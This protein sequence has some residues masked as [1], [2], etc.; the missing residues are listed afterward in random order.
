MTTNLKKVG[1]AYSLFDRAM[2][3]DLRAKADVAES[4]TT[5]DFPILLGQGYQRKL[6]AAYQAQTPVWQ[7]YATRTTVPNFKP[8][9]LVQILGGARGLSRVAEATEYPSRDLS[10]ALFEFSVGKYGDR[11]GLSWEMVVN[12][13]LGA[14]RGIDQSLA[15]AAR[16]TEGTV[17]ASAFFNAAKTGLNTQ[18]FRA[19]NGNA[20]ESAPLTRAALQDAIQE[21]STKKDEQGNPLTRPG[22]VL[23]VPPTL[24][25]QAREIL[26]ASEIRTTDANGAVSV[27]QNPVAGA[28]TLVVEPNLL[29]NTGSNAATT[30][31]LLPAPNSARPAIV[32]GFLAGHEAPDLRVKADTGNRAGGGQVAPEQGSFDDDTIQ[33]R[34]RHV[35]GAALIDPKF[36][37]VSQGA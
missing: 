37:F 21:L 18:F 25:Y 8:Q 10:E 31:F 23:V 15:V 16:D 30:W 20:P 3:G 22:L 29:L 12:D 28:V 27:S 17:T 36:T 5:S 6:L 11:L 7:Q 19:Q 35:V 34:V 1:E 9:R 24:E 26:S 2:N 32:T 33:Y 13:E 4:L 14:F